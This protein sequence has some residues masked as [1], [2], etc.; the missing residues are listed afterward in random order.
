MR[1]PRTLH[2]LDVEYLGARPAFSA[3]DLDLVL[4]RYRPKVGCSPHDHLVG[5]ASNWV[6]KR[7]AFDLDP[8]VRCLAGR[9]LV[10]GDRFRLPLADG[11]QL[12]GAGAVVDQPRDDRVGATL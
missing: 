6:Y 4:D 5:A 2:L 7:I 9:R 3:A 12:P 8:A 1:S 11:G 10:V